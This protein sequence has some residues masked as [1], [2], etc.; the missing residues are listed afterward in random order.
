MTV[1]SFTFV[2]SIAVE[3]SNETVDIV[4][5]KVFREDLFGELDLVFDCKG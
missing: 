4:V 5:F 2:E 1:Q 3:L